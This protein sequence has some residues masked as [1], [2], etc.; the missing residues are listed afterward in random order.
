MGEIV[1]FPA[2]DRAC[3]PAAAP[4]RPWAILDQALITDERDDEGGFVAAIV[5]R[6]V[7]GPEGLQ[8]AVRKTRGRDQGTL[9]VLPAARCVRPPSALRPGSAP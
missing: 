4:P 2:R 7:I 9:R 1:A 8:L 6:L 3:R 5:E